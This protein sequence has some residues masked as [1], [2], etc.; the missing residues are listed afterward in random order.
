M[1][2]DINNEEAWVTAH[3]KVKEYLKYVGSNRIRE[4][5]VVKNP[6]TNRLK[7][8]HFCPICLGSISRTSEVCSKCTE[9]PKKF[10]ISKEDLE[11]L[12]GK[13][14][15]TKIGEMFGVS[16]NA[17]KKR[18]KKLGIFVPP[19][20]GYWQKVKVGQNPKLADEYDI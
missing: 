3:K 11:N 9:R 5:K 17:I 8:Q 14:P 7:E 1:V 12:I 2:N 15:L 10:E 4:V 19:T 6:K 20:R 18:A 13:M 16:D